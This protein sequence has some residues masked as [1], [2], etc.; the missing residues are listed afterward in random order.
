MKME[1][2]LFLEYPPSSTFLWSLRC[3]VNNRIKSSR[4]GRLVYTSSDH[5]TGSIWTQMRLQC[6]PP[7]LPL[8]SFLYLWYPSWAASLTLIS[9]LLLTISNVLLGSVEFH[10]RTAKAENLHNVH[11]RFLDLTPIIEDR[12]RDLLA[13]TIRHQISPSLRKEQVCLLRGTQIADAIARVK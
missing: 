1:P 10:A 12:K 5:G 6:G 7:P 2:P 9:P 13:H 11:D 3:D 4:K 8:C